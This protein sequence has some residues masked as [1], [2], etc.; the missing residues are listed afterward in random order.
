M[1]ETC[2]ITNKT[3]GILILNLPHGV[4]PE[5]AHMAHVGTREE[6]IKSTKVEGG[7][8]YVEIERKIVSHKR[9]V[10]GSITLLAKGQQGDTVEV[11]R[12]AIF[13]PE[14]KSAQQRGL[15]EVSETEVK[16]DDGSADKP[17][18]ADVTPAKTP[19]ALP[20]AASKE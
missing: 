13:A 20:G 12:S 1:P 2:L 6:K 10:S 14:V 18:K 17:K 5:H 16:K 19:A 4:V 11:A 8:K 15:I 3:K 7:R 9:P